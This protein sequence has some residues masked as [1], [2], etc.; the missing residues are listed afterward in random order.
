M[1]REIGVLVM[2]VDSAKATS[3]PEEHQSWEQS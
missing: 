1:I 3:N 2:V